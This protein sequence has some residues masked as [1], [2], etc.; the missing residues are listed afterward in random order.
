MFLRSDHLSGADFDKATVQRIHA[1]WAKCIGTD[2]RDYERC[3]EDHL[4]NLRA[5]LASQKTKAASGL[6]SK[7][8][9][10]RPAEPVQTDTLYRFAICFADTKFLKGHGSR[11]A[12]HQQ[13]NLIH[14]THLKLIDQLL[15]LPDKTLTSSPL[16]RANGTLGEVINAALLAYF[17]HTDYGDQGQR[18]RKDVSL[19]VP[20]LLRRF[21]YLSS[22]LT[23]SLLGHHPDIAAQA[24]SLIRDHFQQD[25]AGADRGIFGWL[26]LDMFG[27]HAQRDDPI[28]KN[29]AKIMSGVLADPDD[30][31]LPQLQ[32]LVR[33]MVNVP[34]GV[35]L[36]TQQ[37]EADA[38]KHTIALDEKQ[39]ADG[40]KS[41]PSG[42]SKEHME[43]LCR[44]RLTKA[45]AKLDTIENDFDAYRTECLAEAAK[46]LAQATTARKGIEAVAKALPT[47]LAAP[48]QDLLSMAKANNDQ[49]KLYPMTKP[50]DND[51]KDLGLK[52]LVI[53]ELMYQQECLAP[54]FDVRAF[55]KEWTKRQISIEEDGYAIIPE[56]KKY[57]QN[58]A[59]PT[60]LLAKVEVLTQKSGLDGDGGA[61]NQIVPFWD[62]GVGDGPIPI[63]NKAVADLE[64]LP[65]LKCI[66]GLEHAVN[67]PKPTK[68][69]KA[70][71]D[72]G[73]NQVHEEL[74]L[75]GE[76]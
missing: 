45:R 60:E 14:D 73:I 30:W 32:R 28:G 68:L 38:A 24:A 16:P 18:L 63:T 12:M 57:F 21:P 36:G 37:E 7:I 70:L 2:F 27:H 1:D 20:H 46:H 62:P 31:P 6:M 9:N 54:K 43:K 76:L 3:F 44:K 52:L 35:N 69:L 4:A 5:L 72:K 65:N 42:I 13:L 34:L 23:V 51:F 56:V 59:I 41:R 75:W 22:N 40:F 8:F 11:Q 25:E 47:D 66:A 61:M 55:A 33:D 53:D 71:A 26:A 17:Y 39:I 50:A 67:T 49:P 48:L 29:A 10:R 64:L 15:E 58:L 19:R 74:A